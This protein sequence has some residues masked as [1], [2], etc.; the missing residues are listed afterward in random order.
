MIS[1]AGDGIEIAPSVGLDRSAANSPGSYQFSQVGLSIRPQ[2][3]RIGSCGDRDI[4]IL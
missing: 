3:S 4:L 2:G 1:P